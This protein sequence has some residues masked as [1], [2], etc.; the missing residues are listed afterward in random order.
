MSN[1]SR[2]VKN[3]TWIV[4]CHIAQAVINLIINMLTARY[5]GPSNYGLI[6]YAASIVAFV[7]PIM[8]LGLN[9]VLVQEIVNNPEKEGET[10]GTALCLNV[11]SSIVTTGFVVLFS[12][13]VNHGEKETIVVCALYSLTLMFQAIMMIQYWFQAKL[14]SKYT[15]IVSLIAYTLVAGYRVVLLVTQ[16]SIY[17]FAVS[18]ALD[19][20][21]IAFSLIIIYRKLGGKKFKFSFNRAKQLL[22]SGRYYVLSAMMVTIFAQTDKIMLKLMINEEATGLYTVAVTCAGMTSFVFAAIIDSFRPVIVKSKAVD[23]RSF[24]AKM[25][26]L[27]SVIIYCSLFQSLLI[28]VL[29]KQIIHV[30]YGSAYSSAAGVLGLVVWYT[31]FSYLG[32]VR[33]VWILSERKEKYL[34]CINLTG[35]LANVILNL[36]LIP[37]Y[38]TIGAALAS[39]ITQI[40]TNVVLG[41]IIRPIRENNKLMVKGLDVRPLVRLARSIVLKRK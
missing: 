41:F 35:A 25:S 18:Q 5:L 33:D 4:A 39:F 11:I 32:A 21:L 23:Q 24:E 37:I 26:L 36:C 19:Y 22:G 29:S 30:L 9:A 31:T 40:F 17:W 38:G 28:S 14:I 27:Y 34:W 1:G 7:V 6:S 8:Q 13:V 15:S 20:L 2:V 16:K 10:L 12:A 3:A